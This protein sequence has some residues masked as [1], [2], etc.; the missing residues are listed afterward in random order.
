[1]TWLIIRVRSTPTSDTLGAMSQPPIV[2]GDEPQ[3]YQPPPI[4]PPPPQQPIP[5]YQVQ[6]PSDVVSK[7]VTGTIAVVGTLILIFCVAPVFFC[8]ACGA[9]GGGLGNLGN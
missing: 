9:I 3:Y 8:V 4:Y 5:V 2:P 1:M 7:S 6:Q